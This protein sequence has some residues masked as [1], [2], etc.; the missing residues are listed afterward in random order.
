MIIQI[1]QLTGEQIICARFRRNGTE[2]T[3][4]SGFCLPFVAT[5]ELGAALKAHCP[6]ASED[7]RTILILPPEM[8]TLRELP[9]PFGDRRKVRAV[10]PLELAG[11]TARESETLLCDAIPLDSGNWLAGWLEKGELE[12]LIEQLRQADLDPEIVT[13]ACLN[14]QYLLKNEGEQDRSLVAIYDD[15]ALLVTNTGKP[16]FCRHPGSSGAT[17]K[18]TIATLELNHKTR[19]SQCFYLG[20]QVQQT[21]EQEKALPLPEALAKGVSSGDM[22]PYSLLSPYAVAMAYSKA[23][24]LFNLRTGA[25]AWTGRSSRL[26]RTFRVPLILLTVLLVLLFTELGI[27]WRLL[28]TD[29]TALD[30]SI[31]KIYKDVFP[32]RKKAMD[33]SAE[34]KAEIKRLEAN[35][36]SLHPLPFLKL[37]SEAKGDG[38]STITEIDLDES[39]FMLKGDANSAVD[40]TTFRQRLMGSAYN[41]DQPEITTRPNK[42]VLFTLRGN[43][44]GNKQ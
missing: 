23:D 30:N 36:S 20:S 33:E 14:W 31:G 41:P 37:L 39:R 8:I 22:P 44:G 5:E 24:P 2:V 17:I 16:F 4:I 19:I 42:S 43:N 6:P 12:P 40:V 34:L 32:D 7:I 18:Q 1:I 9:L 10:L 13:I 29:L 21:V 38:I 25:L 26:L 15:A 35:A 3:P 27:R 11:E 28:A